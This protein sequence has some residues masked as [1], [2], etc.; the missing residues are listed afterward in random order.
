MVADTS[1][2]DRKVSS[3]NRSSNELLPTPE[4]P[5]RSSLNVGMSS[6]LLSLYA[7]Q[8]PKEKTSLLV[9]FSSGCAWHEIH[10]A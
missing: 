10:H 3:V 5:M 1:S 8:F 9:C 2:W 4:L 7:I 6:L